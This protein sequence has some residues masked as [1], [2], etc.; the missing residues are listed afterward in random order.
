MIT[1][2]NLAVMRA[3]AAA[4]LI[5][6]LTDLLR[7]RD[8]AEILSW[9]RGRPAALPFWMACHWLEISPLATRERLQKVAANPSAYREPLR[10]VGHRTKGR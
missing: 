3:L 9:V 10:L 1:V 7:G 2:L 4:V 6:A 5:R 8:T